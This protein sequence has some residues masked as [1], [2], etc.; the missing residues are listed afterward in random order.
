MIALKAKEIDKSLGLIADI[1]DEK[2]EGLKQIGDLEKEILKLN[3]KIS[4]VEDE[5]VKLNTNT[6]QVTDQIEKIE[7]KRKKLE[8]HIELEMDTMKAE[9]EKIQENIEKLGSE[10]AENCRK[11]E[12]LATLETPKAVVEPKPKENTSRMTD[13]LAQS[14]KEKEVDLECPV[15]FETASIPIFMCSEMHL[16]CNRCRPKIRECPECRLPYTGAAKRHR[17]AE[18]TAGELGKLRKEYENLTG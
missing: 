9:G 11:A 12:N 17:F 13:F 18:K 2:Q 7:K 4:A 3:S 16:I 5:K 6:E 15:C 8:K 10:L 14:I 1:K